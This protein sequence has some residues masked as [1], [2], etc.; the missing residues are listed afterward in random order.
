MSFWTDHPDLAKFFG[1]G[2]DDPRLSAP[3]GSPE[4]SAAFADAFET[5]GVPDVAGSSA[6]PAVATPT[7]A[8]N[9]DFGGNSG[10]F[11]QQFTAPVPGGVHDSWADAIEN[12]FGKLQVGSAILAVVIVVVAVAYVVH[13]VA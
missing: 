3:E 5:T 12:F 1:V 13:K 11:S 4:R 10:Y 7:E 9:P 8:A 2:G 6:H